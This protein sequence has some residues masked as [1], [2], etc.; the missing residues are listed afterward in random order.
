V[1]AAP[2]RTARPQRSSALPLAL[3]AVALIAASVGGVYWW[4]NNQLAKDNQAWAAAEL[5]N[6]IDSYQAY[7]RDEP[8]GQHAEEAD[9]RI[10][11]LEWEAAVKLNTVAAYQTYKQI[12][13]QHGRHLADADSGIAALNEAA[14]AAADAK[15]RQAAANTQQAALTPQQAPAAAQQS[16]PG[17]N[18]ANAA[19]EADFKRAL[20]LHTSAEYRNFLAAHGSSAHV[21]EIRQRLASCQMVKTGTAVAQKSSI[22]ATGKGTGANR[23]Q[24]CQ[25]ARRDGMSRL[26]AQCPG[27]TVTWLRNQPLGFSPAEGCSIMVYGAC[28]ARASQAETERCR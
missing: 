25:G 15:A 6:S 16:S 27:G 7:L 14:K 4:K 11:G 12:E 19:E 3:A 5:Q 21:A 24:A 20:E 9:L 17:G 18:Q 1:V 26:D 28:A 2:I 10:D 8:K 22:Q 13:E 23:F